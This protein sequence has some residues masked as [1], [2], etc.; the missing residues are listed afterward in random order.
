MCQFRKEGRH[1]NSGGDI[2]VKDNRQGKRLTV[3]LLGG[4]DVRVGEVVV[5]GFESQKSRA[6]FAYLAIHHG[7]AINREQLSA[8]LWP[9]KREAPA[10][11]NLRQALYNIRTTLQAF[12][13]TRD[14]L[15]ANRLSVQL[16]PDLH[17]WLDTTE[18]EEALRVGLAGGRSDPHM[19]AV[20]ARLYRGDF[21]AGFPV[22]GSVPFE[23]WLFSEQERLREMAVEALRSLV[24]I[25]F[26]RGEYRI[27]LR[28]AQRLVAIDPLSEEAHCYLMRLY[29]MAGRRGRALEHFEHLTRT[30][31]RELG[32]EPA[33]ETVALHQSIL[34]D[35]MPPSRIDRGD[36]PMAPLI[37]LVGRADALR[38]LEK[39]WSRVRRGESQVSFVAGPGGVGKSRLVRTVLDTATSR[40]PG[41]VLQG[42]C[43][44]RA[45]MV[46][47]QPFSEILNEVLSED[48]SAV[49]RALDG[50]PAALID[51]IR[52]MARVAQIEGDSG[53][54]RR[55]RLNRKQLFDAVRAVLELYTRESGT[56][57]EAPPMILFLDD[58]QWADEPSLDLLDHLLRAIDGTPMWVILGVRTGEDRFDRALEGRLTETVGDRFTRLDLG[59]LSDHDLDE[60]AASLV[61][62]E[63]SGRLRDFLD[64][65]SGRMPQTL[66]ELVNFLWDEKILEPYS[67]TEWRLRELPESPGSGA[68]EGARPLIRRRIA[69][70]P[71]SVRR[72]MTVA[73]VIGPKFDTGLLTGAADEHG[74]VVEIGIEVALERWLLRGSLPFWSTPGREMDLVLWARGARRGWFEFA[75]ETIR[76]VVLE[77][78]DERRRRE[79]HR[80]IAAAL[81]R[82]HHRNPDRV[83][84]ELAFHWLEGREPGR[85]AHHL[86]HAAAAA[87]DLGAER[88]ALDFARL[89]LMEMRRPRRA[90]SRTG[91]EAEREVTLKAMQTLHDKLEAASRLRASSSA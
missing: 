52:R 11:R 23:E 57:R 77:S 91:D 3:R 89:A 70:L 34:E 7:Q 8:L 48:P 80:R 15:D 55:G 12:P 5:T 50:G 41:L 31:E 85:A 59:L 73:A 16:N 17:F 45:A 74:A 63:S 44:Q 68:E 51:R 21:L 79:I 20:A 13:T 90:V 46:N 26:T 66:A 2:L 69:Q 43:Y 27:G 33:D 24:E 60:I 54:V 82:R 86:Y 83:R 76:Q 75:H 87:A 49:E 47:Y 30:L 9:D 39:A 71:A 64:R 81:E 14:A 40:D 78:L 88:N 56:S 22:K 38:T 37:P 58:M 32:V 62:S 42:R 18:F 1:P 29:Q 19:L 28:M 65:F 10:R 35:E 72:L 67:A 84:E 36:Q 6:L 53:P 61:G 4:F 25:Y